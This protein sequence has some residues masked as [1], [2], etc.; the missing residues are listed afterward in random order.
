MITQIVPVVYNNQRILTTQQLAEFYETDTDRISE[1][2][3][4]NRDRYVA[5]KHYFLLE[6]RELKKFKVD[7]PAICG[8]VSR[9]NKLYL[10]TEKGAVRHAKHLGTEKAWDV[11]EILEET[12]FRVQELPQENINEAFSRR[13]NENKWLI[14]RMRF[15]V[16]EKTDFIAI[17]GHLI[18]LGF[19]YNAFLDK[20]L[21]IG[22]YSWCKEQGYDMS[23]VRHTEKER[24]VGW[25]LN[26]D[27]KFY[28]FN[29]PI[30]KQVY[31]YPEHPFG[32]AWSRYL[33][34]YYWPERFLP[35]IKR[36]YKGEERA[37]NIEAGIRVINFY[38]GA[39]ITD[40]RKAS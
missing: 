30:Y 1:N 2:Y 36:K 4:R 38:T 8:F 23:L 13:R 3:S 29:K 14:E 21:G 40:S 9:I 28:N 32:Y 11:W 16:D 6:G 34:E 37:K 24:L 15:T 22:F 10:W 12:Y 25:E 19:A 31:S 18:A 20:S 35:Y 7:N 5:G 17:Q 26:E 27:G 33:V 39:Q